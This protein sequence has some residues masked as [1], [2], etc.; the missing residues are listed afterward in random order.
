MV[1]LHV[2][3]DNIIILRP[4][5]WSVYQDESKMRVLRRDKYFLGWNETKK[6]DIR[7]MYVSLSTWF[8]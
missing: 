4:Y 2:I 7:A 5:Y 1:L 3:D 6:T 8:F